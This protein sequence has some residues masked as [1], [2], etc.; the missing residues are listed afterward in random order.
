MTVDR[1]TESERSPRAFETTHWSLVLS[2]GRHSSPDAREALCQLCEQYWY[3]LYAFVRRRVPDVHEAQDLTQAFFAQLLEKN[4]VAQADPERG[5]FRTFLLSSLCHFLSN[6]W[7]KSQAKKRGGDRLH[8]SLNFDDGERRL[9]QDP[10]TNMTAERDYERQ[11]AISLL[12]HVLQSLRDD[13]VGAGREKQFEV[14]KDC[15]TGNRRRSYA[16]IAEELNMS[17][18]AVK[19][20]VHRLRRQYGRRLRRAI[21][22]TVA[23]PNDIDEEIRRLFGALS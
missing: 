8:F 13:A 14:L 7:D 15:L 10:A 1:T 17:E 19:T 16:E 12:Q 9:T 2:A 3:P 4:Y 11:W 23:K 22:E 20:A 18:P 5:K 21:A 6:E